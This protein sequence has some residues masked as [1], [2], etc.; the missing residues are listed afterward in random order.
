MHMA[1]AEWRSAI[2]HQKHYLVQAFWIKAPEIPH[3]G[4]AFCICSR[5]SFLCM[6]KIAEFLWILYKEYWSIISYQ[7]PV[8]IFRIKF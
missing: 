4:R 5:I 3:H 2:A 8:A 7:V 6:D 1:V